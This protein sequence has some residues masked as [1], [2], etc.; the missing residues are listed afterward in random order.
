MHLLGDGE[1][2]VLWGTWNGLGFDV[3]VDRTWT[4]IYIPNPT[5][6]N[7]I[8]LDWSPDLSSWRR[9]G[10]FTNCADGLLLVDATG[11]GERMRFYRVVVIP[12][13]IPQ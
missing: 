3:P 8:Q 10:Y 13:P 7:F 2:G 6:S 1:T 12:L 11:I 5:G 4:Q 9:I